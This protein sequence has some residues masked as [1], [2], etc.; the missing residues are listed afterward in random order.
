MEELI[1]RNGAHPTFNAL[2]LEQ[3]MKIK[4]RR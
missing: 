3:K 2:P 4:D 1:R